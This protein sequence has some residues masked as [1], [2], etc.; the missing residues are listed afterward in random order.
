MWDFFVCPVTSFSWRFQLR[1]RWQRA[2][3]RQGRAR[4]RSCFRIKLNKMHQI[5]ER[6][7]SLCGEGFFGIIWWRFIKLTWHARCDMSV[8]WWCSILWANCFNLTAI[9]SRCCAL[10][11]E[12]V[13]IHSLISTASFCV[14]MPPVYFPRYQ[15][16]LM[17]SY[18][19]W[20][21]IFSTY[22]ELKCLMSL[23]ALSGSQLFTKI[24]CRTCMVSPLETVFLI[25][26]CLRL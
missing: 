8:K 1:R 10:I 20:D 15:I 4:K 6:S 9:C 23:G 17:L 5:T 7:S 19:M 12:C 3:G 26:I 25:R 13:V 16:S 11:D 21:F 14:V 18:R 22:L 24:L 2:V